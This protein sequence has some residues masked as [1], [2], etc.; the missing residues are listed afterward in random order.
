MWQLRLDLPD[1]KACGEGWRAPS[2]AQ[3]EGLRRAHRR[4][5]LTTASIPFFFDTNYDALLLP[6][7]SGENR[8]PNIRRRRIR[9]RTPGRNLRAHHHALRLRVASIEA[10]AL[11]RP[12]AG[13]LDRIS[14]SRSP[15][16]KAGLKNAAGGAANLP[17]C[18]GDVRQDREGRRPATFATK[19]FRFSN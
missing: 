18:G 15:V 14:P 17:P 4:A 7:C 11:R 9:C 3:S 8:R 2:Q 6:S 13:P 19:K 12:L 16:S 10:D 5:T 1:P